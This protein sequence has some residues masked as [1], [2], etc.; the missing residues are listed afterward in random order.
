MRKK[1]NASS[2]T[3]SVI[4]SAE[5][6]PRGPNVSEIINKHRH[7]LDTDDTLKQLFPK[8]SIIVANKRG[9]N[10]QE[11]LTRADPYNIKSDL[12]DL[13]VH[14]Y[15]KCGK[16]CDSCNNF[17]DETSFIILKAT[18]RKYW[19]RRDSTST[20]KNVIYWAYCTK[21]G[22]QGTGS[23]VSWKPRLS[24]YKSHTH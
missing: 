12:L 11:H 21:C 18:G 14:G 17:V 2:R 9:R 24:N 3:T 8:N 19:I 10:L 23:T 1:K 5:S 4:F 6:N 22:E 7:L 16:K 15:K 20:R 13:N